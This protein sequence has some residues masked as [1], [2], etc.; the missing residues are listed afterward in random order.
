MSSCINVKRER[1]YVMND[2]VFIIFGA[3]GDLVKRKLIPAL[4]R[5]V[6]K[7]KIERFA[8]IG[9]A[10]SDSSAKQI[11]DGA[12]PFVDTHFDQDT[13]DY[14]R[15]R[16]EYHILDFNNQ[17]DFVSL[18]E[19]VVAIEKKYNLSGN[20][21]F[22]CA[23]AARFF[24]PITRAI[25][26]IRLG[27]KKEKKDSAWHRIVYEK[28]FGDD[29]FS[30]HDINSCVMEWFN[31]HQ[32]YRVD[33]YLSKEL[34]SNIALIR[35]TNCV[36]EPL[37]N[38]RYIDQVHINLSEN[39]GIENRG[40]YYDAYG[41]LADVVQNHMLQLLALVGMEAPQLLSGDY[42][43]EQRARVLAD[44]QV[45][46]GIL[47]QYEGY[48]HEHN[49]APDSV[50]ET[51]AYLFLRINNP[52]WAGVPFFLKTGKCLDKRKIVIHIKFK[53]VDCLF[54]KQ[55]PSESNW[56]TIE[57]YP[58]ATF[59][60][61]LNAKKPGSTSELIPVAMEFCHSC[62]FGDHVPAAYEV[63][64]ENVLQGEQ[65]GAVRFD[66]LESAWNI[67]GMIKQKQLPLYTYK[68]GSEGPT[69][70]ESFMH[71]HGVKKR[72]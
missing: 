38:N 64:L 17:A 31:E 40:A 14:I 30:A 8:F 26:T 16:F 25:G 61:T 63:L 6:Q 53:Q 22:Y 34:V 59:Y 71:K 21:L 29:L 37:W 60:V 24:I 32:I 27:V 9:A 18:K 11:M 7:G 13:W 57:V 67:I 19:Q 4:Y 33:H 62:I 69:Q 43:R 5:L 20:R 52:R 39:F 54:T 48:L 10:I 50:T 49:V 2:V 70:L 41:A 23:T 66:E 44:V 47:G 15:D 28:P 72:P 12:R 55:C 35:F 68:K 56:L 1:Y 36:F 65:E 46:D 45:V 3:T 51:F 42:V 58:N